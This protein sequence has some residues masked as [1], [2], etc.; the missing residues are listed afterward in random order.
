MAPEVTHHCRQH[1]LPKEHGGVTPRWQVKPE[2]PVE[3]ATTNAVVAR[4]IL[5]HDHGLLQEIVRSR[6]DAAVP[7]F[8]GALR[9]CRLIKTHAVV[10]QELGVPG[11]HF[12]GRIL[13]IVAG[14]G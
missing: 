2:L 4:S 13:D 6:H 1:E 8:G 7:T 3:R 10:S 5:R 12:V 14:K 9:R 11:T